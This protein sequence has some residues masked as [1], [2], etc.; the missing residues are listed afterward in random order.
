MALTAQQM[1]ERMPD[2]RQLLSDDPEMES[3]V[4]YPQL[5]LTLSGSHHRV[6]VGVHGGHR[7]YC[8]KDAVPGRFPDT[9]VFPVLT[10]D[11]GVCRFSLDQRAVRGDSR[12]R[13]QSML[14]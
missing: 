14:E 3:S 11:P 7:P 8:E 1:A 13:R 10:G 6:A 12:G 4:H 9:R 5:A 2:A